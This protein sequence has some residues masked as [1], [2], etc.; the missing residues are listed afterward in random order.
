[1]KTLFIIP[2]RGGSKGILGKNSKPLGGKPLIHYSIEFARLFATDEHIC[3]TTDSQI[4]ADCATEIGYNAPFL[5]PDYLATDTSGSYE[6]LLHALNFYENLGRKYDTVVLLQPTSPFR[7]KRHL[8]EAMQIYN[9]EMQ[10]YNENLDMIVS[11]CEAKGNPYYNL[12]EENEGGFL[13]ISKGDGSFTRRQDVPPVFE[14]NGSIYII[15]TQSLK[16]KNG[17]K[18]F[19]HIKKYVM[20]EAYSIDLDTPTDWEKAEFFLAL[21]RF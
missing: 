4:I 12:F 6:V 8:D 5:R 15:N 2:A 13:K 1:M 19:E 9:N 17:M 10:L 20:T 3:L 14:Y 11:V 16:E 21:Q 18:A 7:E